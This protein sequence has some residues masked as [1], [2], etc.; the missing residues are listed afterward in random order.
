[1]RWRPTNQK[2]AQARARTKTPATTIPAIAPLEREIPWWE[3]EG[4]E[5]EEGVD[6]SGTFSPGWSIISELFIE[7]SWAASE[8]VAF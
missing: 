3:G 8:N 5:V 1:M 6:S 2:S 7:V 4:E